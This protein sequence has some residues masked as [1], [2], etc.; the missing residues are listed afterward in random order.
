MLASTFDYERSIYNKV[1]AYTPPRMVFVDLPNFPVK[2]AVYEFFAIFEWT[3]RISH[4]D[5]I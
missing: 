5:V 1:Y 4:N 3:K 2:G